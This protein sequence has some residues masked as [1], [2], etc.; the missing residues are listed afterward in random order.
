MSGRAVIGDVN[1]W[2]AIA[3]EIGADDTQAGSDG[4]SNSGFFGDVFECAV[5]AIMEKT[6]RYRLVHFRR[7]IVPLT[8]R[9]ITLLVSFHCEVQIVRYKKVQAPVVVIIDPRGAG[10]PTRVVHPGLD[11]NIG[12]S[13]VTVV[14]IENV[15]SKVCDVEV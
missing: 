6:R 5:A 9:G 2:P 1:I 14:V 13:T 3:V 11:R 12:E 4:C 8:S 7:A 15:L 10:A